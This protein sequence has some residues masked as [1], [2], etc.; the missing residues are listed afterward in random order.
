M[1]ASKNG[2]TSR[3]VAQREL[4]T[5]F[6]TIHQLKTNNYSVN[7]VKSQYKFV[8]EVLSYD[9]ATQI[10]T[11]RQRNLFSVGDEIEFMVQDS[12]ISVKPLKLCIMKKANPLTEHQIQ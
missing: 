1:S 5:G 2:S 11:I 10:A 7:V 12:V 3:K 6:T 4:A 9:E 8:G